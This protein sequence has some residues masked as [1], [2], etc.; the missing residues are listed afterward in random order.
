MPGSMYCSL[1]RSHKRHA[2]A[3]GAKPT[4]QRRMSVR[5]QRSLCY[6]HF[7]IIIVS[8]TAHSG[9]AW[10]ISQH[11]T[12]MLWFNTQGTKGP[13][14]RSLTR[15]HCK[16]PYHQTGRRCHR[17]VAWRK[18]KALVCYETTPADVPYGSSARYDQ[19]GNADSYCICNALQC[20]WPSKHLGPVCHHVFLATF[21]KL[22]AQ[23]S[24]SLF[25]SPVAAELD[26]AVSLQAR[27]S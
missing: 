15:G 6:S 26:T 12:S 24:G 23:S 1:H 11:D 3:V 7:I 16:Y 19:Y 8:C 27:N 14:F 5:M 9:V 22:G 13:G 2:V 10:V 25:Q 21:L 4:T 20:A 17:L 18:N